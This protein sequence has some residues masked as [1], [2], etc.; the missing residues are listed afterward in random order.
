MSGKKYWLVFIGA[1]LIPFYSSATLNISSK[2]DSSK[3]CFEYH[4]GTVWNAKL[5][6][7]IVQSGYPDI[8]IKKADFYSE[9]FVSPHYW[10][11]RFTYWKKKY[12]FSFEAIHHKL[13]L[14]NKPPEVKRFGISHGYNM[15]VISVVR[16]FKYVNIHLGG[17]SVLLHP[18]S[19]IRG[20]VWPEGPGFDWKG[21]RLRGGVLNIAAS[22]KF[23]IWKRFYVN[24][25]GK[26][27]FSRAITPVVDGYAIVNNIALQFLFGIG[28]DFAYNK[29]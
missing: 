8:Y 15:L 11:W 12:G 7:T 5:P 27:T 13:Y 28:I 4:F 16:R 10:D 20:K 18:E 25:E 14:K 3:I 2:K 1:C 19:T 29:H 17:G 26:S 22:H 24:T 23:K 6:L 9:P 21:Y